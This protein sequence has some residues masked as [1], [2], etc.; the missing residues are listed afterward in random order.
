MPAGTRF[1]VDTLEFRAVRDLLMERLRTA[2]GR[3]DVEELVPF[4]TADE[5][6]RAATAA[7]ELAGRLDADDPPPTGGAVEVRSWLGGFMAGE[8]Q[9]DPREIAEL[10]RVLRAASRCRG[11][12][13]SRPGC[14]EL[15]RFAGRFPVIDDLV[16]ELEATVDDR[17]E[18]LDTASVRLAQIRREI[19]EADAE[20]RAAIHRF[21]ADE[22]MR[23]VLQSP[24]PSWRHGRP[25]FQVRFEKR[26]EVPGV[27]HDR[28]QSG[29]TAFVEP[30][31]VVA[32][33][34]RLSDVRA[35]EHR[36]IQVVLTHVCRGLRRTEADV[37]AAVAAM[38][39][40]DLAV[41]R[42]RLIHEDG[43]R[44]VPVVD[45]GPLRLRRALHP[46]LLTAAA[47][48]R[49]GGELVPLDLTL[50]DPYAM[51]VI[52]GPNTGGK[53]V[54]L[55]TVGLLS[56]MAQ[57]G[58][59]IPAD[60]GS[61]LPCFD[62]VFA[63]IGDE[64][65][66]SQNLSTFSSHVTRIARCL[67][68]ATDRSLVLL[69]ELG[70]GTDPEEGGALGTAVLEALARRGA[71]AVVTTHLGR[72][73]DFA[74]QN[75]GV[76]NGA[77]AFDGATLS[78]LYR[79]DVGIPGASHALDIAGRVGMPRDLVARAR[80]VLGTRDHSLED[81]IER[82]QVARREAEDQRR[83]T[84]ELQRAAERTERDL[85]ERRREIEM[86]RAWLGEEADAVVDEQVRVIRE[87]L[88]DPLKQ[89]S[90][91]PRP[92]GDAARE[93]LRQLER[94]ADGT[95]IHRRRM[96]FVG[97]IRQ[98]QAVYVPRLGKR[99]VVKRIDKL[100]ETLTI[101]VG[102][103]RMDIPFEDASWLQPLD[104]G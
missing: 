39:A 2:L 32:A 28:S 96:R 102:R 94:L 52:T 41:A 100:R 58:V 24:E 3:R 103:I 88:A 82:V 87:R 25:V 55:K 65:G 21:L 70:A 78:P 15:A 74:Y 34:N 95:S 83:R 91:A 30:Q 72:L 101:E 99:C 56:L 75:E 31:V 71:L 40:L 104:A 90:S 93:L 14:P 81:V 44:A 66:I 43:F 22:R 51:L 49:D 38:G 92:H 18:V 79:L 53:T 12:L 29:A 17:G 26:H 67:R 69:D 5:A 10:K 11:W 80:E 13:E 48:R 76:E 9:P 6:N 36:E 63:D 46:L 42:A 20:V 68:E 16:G 97:G 85:E 77:M 57:A 89:L 60:E 4:R 62:G 45:G 33:A 23:R 27:V 86:Q 64:Q 73:K 47:A 84:E 35:D 98:N 19:E 50:G 59:P 7:R 1:D 61:Q 8:H 37:L 54:A